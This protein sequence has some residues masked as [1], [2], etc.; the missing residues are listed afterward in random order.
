MSNTGAAPLPRSL[1]LLFALPGILQTFATGP[2]I[3]LLQ[4]IYAKE[5][6]ITLVAI[7]SA[8]LFVRIFD[9]FSDLAIGYLSDRTVQRGGSRKPWMLAGTVVSV[10]SLWFL[11]RPP[12]PASVEYF[13]FW[14]LVGN[15]GWSLIEIPYRT[16][17]LELTRDYVQRTRVVTWI[18]FASMLG[19]LLVYAVPF[20]AKALGLMATAE[21]NLQALGYMAIVIAVVLPPLNLLALARVPSGE[22]GVMPAGVEKAASDSFSSLW[23]SVIGN[24]PLMRFILCFAL[25]TFLGNLPQGVSFI[26]MTNY[27]G[28]TSEVG[29]V[30]ALSIPLSFLGVPFWGWLATKMPRQRVWAIATA[31]M[32]MAC[33]GQGFLAPH[34]NLWLMGALYAVLLFCALSV[35]VVAPAILGDIIDYGKREFGVDRAGLY[36]S[37][38]AQ[39]L[40]GISALAAGA[41]LIMLGRM[42]FDATKAG[43]ELTPQAVAAL[44][45]V[46]A[47]MPAIGV[48]LTVPMLWTFPI[49]AQEPAEPGTGPG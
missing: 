34:P 18:A 37:F 24:K 48:L 38:Q 19:G 46:V 32:G 43:A 31:L 49:G 42:G 26:Y 17:S 23:R 10:I 9:C 6:G 3:S 4:G 2:T 16:W 40:K 8:V 20:G 29:G 30:L 15:V 36:M 28:L 25:T 11:Y 1:L 5:S 47:W 7:G 21:F 35:I 13:A 44:K 33:A 39:V 14:F 41:G 45:W 22:T 27:L 12:V